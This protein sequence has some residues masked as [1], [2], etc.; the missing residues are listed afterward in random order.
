MASA[1]L[2][3]A[4]ARGG[5]YAMGD[6][7]RAATPPLPPLAPFVPVDFPGKVTSLQWFRGGP[8]PEL[9]GLRQDGSL[10]VQLRADLPAPTPTAIE[11]NETSNETRACAHCAKPVPATDGRGPS[12][13]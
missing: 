9:L 5:E 12:R 1:R 11:R 6:L 8:P 3:A 4:L 7:L 2:L 10:A 13:L